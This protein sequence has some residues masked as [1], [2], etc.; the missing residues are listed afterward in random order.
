MKNNNQAEKIISIYEEYRMEPHPTQDRFEEQGKQVFAEKINSFMEK[1]E[2]IQFAMLGYPFKSTNTATKVL[3]TLPDKGEE[4]SIQRLED[5][6]LKIQQVYSPGAIINV[7]SDGFVFNDLLEVEEQTV[8][9]YKEICLDMSSG[10]FNI[11]DITDFFPNITKGR[12][13][14]MNE[15]ALTETELE[16]KILYDINTNWLYRGMIRFMEEELYMKTFASKSQKHK[17][18]KQLTRQMMMRNEAWSRFVSSQFSDN[19]RL[20]MHQSI[21]NGAKFSFDLIEGAQHSPWHS[22]VVIDGDKIFTMHKK[23]AIEQGYILQQNYF[24]KP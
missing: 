21:N 3:G 8:F 11:C 10:S 15:F 1:K 7:A 23:D 4:L 18:A 2:P 12:I 19:I 13:Q 16:R 24:T 22:V 9:Q 6:T 17:A 14:L 20:S 5:F